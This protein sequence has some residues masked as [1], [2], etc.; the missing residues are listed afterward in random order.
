MNAKCNCNNCSQP[1]EFPAEMAGKTVECPNCKLE[2]ILFIPPPPNPEPTKKTEPGKMLPASSKPEPPPHTQSSHSN[3]PFFQILFQFITAS[4]AV[5]CAILI[6]QATHR[7]ELETAQPS[8]EYSE[9]EYASSAREMSITYYDWKP[10]PSDQLNQIKSE[11]RRVISAD[12]TLSVLGR[13]GWQLA[14][15]DGNRYLM[16]RPEGNWRHTSFSVGN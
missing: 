11:P 7:P 4:A 12:E 5:V 1:I 10:T 8:W 15:T 9:F 14:W 13:D 2:T 3:P 6:Y 16:K